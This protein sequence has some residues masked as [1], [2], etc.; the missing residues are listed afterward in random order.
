[1]KLEF[2]NINPENWTEINQI[3]DWYFEQWNIPKEK[4]ISNIQ[5]LSDNIVIFQILMKKENRPIGTG[6]LYRKVGIHNRIKKFEDY[7]PW[8][9]LMYTKEEE[10]GNGLGGELLQ[11]IELEAKK[12]GFDRIYLYTYTAKSLY[13]RKG[14]N[15][16][17]RYNVEGRNIVVMD[18]KL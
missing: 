9:A 10:R 6:G 12:K 17:D 11:Q 2:Q 18:K 7:S 8:L 1:M 15:E 16:I 5:A 13:K 14:W 4:T 3:A